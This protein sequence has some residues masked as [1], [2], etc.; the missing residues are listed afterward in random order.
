M[1]LEAVLA[2]DAQLLQAARRDASAFQGFEQRYALEVVRYF[3]ARMGESLLALDLAAET[4][5]T[6]RLRVRSY[7]ARRVSPVTW[8]YTI[9]RDVL[10]SS[11]VEGEVAGGS[12]RRLRWPVLVL[13]DD[14]LQR[15][16][17]ACLRE[18]DRPLRLLDAVPAHLRSAFATRVNRPPRCSALVDGGYDP[19]IRRACKAS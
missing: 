7:R 10:V 13:A 1:S 12:R 6:V 14:D 8:L 5:A 11:V 19:G 15:V 3:H 18:G 4:F 16:E 17:R 9:A 2:T